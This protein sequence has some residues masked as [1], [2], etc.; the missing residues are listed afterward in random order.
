MLGN[1]AMTVAFAPPMLSMIV[2]ATERDATAGYAPL[3]GAM[4]FSPAV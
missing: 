2:A 4:A 1:T 3:G